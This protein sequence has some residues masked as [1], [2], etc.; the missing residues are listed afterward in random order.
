M[1]V[2]KKDIVT[3][4]DRIE[5]LEGVIHHCWIHSGYSDCGSRKMT[6]EEFSLYQDAVRKES[7]RLDGL[8]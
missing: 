8:S 4:M 7:R 1:E 6:E 2:I 3:L 5:K